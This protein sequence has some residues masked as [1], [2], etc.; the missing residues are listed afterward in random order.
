MI[1]SE[2]HMFFNMNALGHIFSLY[3]L[4]VVADEGL[5]IFSIA[6]FRMDNCNLK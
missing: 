4:A 5:G 2:G 1:S 3:S 6:V